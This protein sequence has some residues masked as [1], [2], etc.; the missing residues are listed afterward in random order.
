MVIQEGKTIRS[1]GDTK[2]SK[3]VTV[4][5]Y[6]QLEEQEDKQAIAAFIVERFD[7][8]YFNPVMNSSSKHG[9]TMMAVGCLVIEALESFHHG[10]RDSSGKNPFDKF[11]KRQHAEGKSLGV[12][13]GDAIKFHQNIRNG[14]LH[15]AETKGGW[16]IMRSGD[17]LDLNGKTINADRFIRELRKIVVEY[18]DQLHTDPILWANFKKKMKRVCANCERGSAPVPNNP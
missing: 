3:S 4:D 7:E 11:F 9:F 16:K 1:V 18:A 8:R 13:A 5:K 6:K 10:W 15:Q 17:L 12:F 2:L 14:I